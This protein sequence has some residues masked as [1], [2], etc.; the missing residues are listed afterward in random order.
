[1]KMNDEF[2]RVFGQVIANRRH[3]MGISQEDLSSRAGINRTY[4]GD[5]ERGARNVALLNIKRLSLALGTTPSKLLKEVENTIS[6]SN[7]R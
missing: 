4:I 2:L 1:M 3:K 6:R 7:E 5:I